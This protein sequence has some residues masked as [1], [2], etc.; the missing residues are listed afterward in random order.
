MSYPVPVTGLVVATALA[1]RSDIGV[2]FHWRRHCSQ[3]CLLTVFSSEMKRLVVIKLHKSVHHDIVPATPVLF[4]G[5]GL[6]LT[7][8][9][10]C[11][12]IAKFTSTHLL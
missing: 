9:T 2:T 7:Y 11:V 12:N 3:Q 8:L 4:A 10:G 6:Y 1:S 5:Q